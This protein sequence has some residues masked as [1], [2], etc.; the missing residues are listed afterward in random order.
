MG[1]RSC[2]KPVDNLIVNSRCVATGAPGYNTGINR[3]LEANR[4]KGDVSHCLCTRGIERWLRGW[5]Q[6]PV[7]RRSNVSWHITTGQ[8]YFFFFVNI[9][10]FFSCLR[11]VFDDLSSL[12]YQS[13][14][15]D[16]INLISKSLNTFLATKRT[17]PNRG[18]EM[19]LTENI[20]SLMLQ[21]GF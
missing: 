2:Q 17:S 18:L 9:C 15:S 7:E 13:L 16:F 4:V 8:T 5:N 21:V 11:R 1:K 12:D 20:A 3:S 10:P 14:G 19:E 6:R